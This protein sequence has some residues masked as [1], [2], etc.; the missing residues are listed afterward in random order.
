MGM[1]A[2]ACGKTGVCYTGR[3]R[4]AYVV[5]GRT[6]VRVKLPTGKKRG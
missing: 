2:S 6:V 5:V 1:F 4:K 3:S